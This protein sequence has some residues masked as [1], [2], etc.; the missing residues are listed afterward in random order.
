MSMSDASLH[1]CASDGRVTYLP[2][3]DPLAVDVGGGGLVTEP[4]PVESIPSF[5]Y[6]ERQ[7]GDCWVCAYADAIR[8]GRVEVPRP[9]G[10]DERDYVLVRARA[11][12]R[13]SHALAAAQRTLAEVDSER[14][15][16]ADATA[17]HYRLA[18]PDEVLQEKEKEAL[19][20]ALATTVRRALDAT[21]LGATPQQAVAMTA[22]N[23]P[24]K[25]DVLEIPPEAVDVVSVAKRGPGKKRPKKFSG[26]GGG[27]RSMF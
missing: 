14:R 15:A 22:E 25:D 6:D 8:R 24:I 17:P 18:T 1:L 23:A 2:A 11:R 20:V 26:G 19:V 12:L 4:I 3:L 5:D 9:S 21:S 10:V 7:D 16:A 13:T 27:Q